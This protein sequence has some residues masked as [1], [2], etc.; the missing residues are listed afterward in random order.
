MTTMAAP[1][2]DR[3]DAI[4]GRWMRDMAVFLAAGAT[5]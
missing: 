2:M 5:W 3:G 4:A 1:R